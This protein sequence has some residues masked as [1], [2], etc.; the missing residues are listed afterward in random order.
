[1]SMARHIETFKR[2]SVLLLLILSVLTSMIDNISLIAN[3][4]F[5]AYVLLIVCSFLVSK[6]IGVDIIWGV[7]F[8]YVILSEMLFLP[9]YNFYYLDVVRYII[10]GNNIILGGYYS[11]K[12][13]TS[14]K[15]GRYELTN[16][17]WF[18]FFLIAM[19]A[20]YIAISLPHA[21]VAM[22]RGRYYARGAHVGGRFGSFVEDFEYVIP[23]FWGY[24][25]RNQKRGWVTSL[26]FSLPVFVIVIMSGT[27]FPLI[28]A[29]LG[30]A[31]ST[32][33]FNMYRFKTKHILYAALILFVTVLMT[34]NMMS[35]RVA[36]VDERGEWGTSRVRSNK[37][38]AQRI[39]SY[40]S[41]EGVIQANTWLFDYCERNGYTYGKQS[42]FF[43]Y[44]WV[45]R[46]VWK[47]KPEMTGRW[48]PQE[49]G[50]FRASHSS[51]I[52]IWGELYV[53]FGYYSFIFLFLWG[54]LLRRINS[55]CK[56][57][58]YKVSDIHIILVPILFSFVFF[59]VRSPI[60]S[61][62]AMNISAIIYFVFRYSVCKKITPINNYGM[63]NL[64]IRN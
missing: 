33:L 48:L 6:E 62:I 23:A 32:G 64:E 54:L 35:S 17:A 38:I 18:I 13:K 5:Y 25:F 43:L 47:D 52:G 42:A 16:R 26:L 49:Y 36:G 50:T 29:V 39:V 61:F 10:I 2:F 21:L 1:M 40:G 28:F 34:N 19:T 24:C 45:P 59:A 63:Q 53:D 7:G 37:S 14:F 51:S 44:W 4:H 46:S 41:D 60:T 55:Y 8:I 9:S 22:E 15:L 58:S 27:R 56:Y 11:F 30:W 3:L 31:L 57:L 20:L 12:D